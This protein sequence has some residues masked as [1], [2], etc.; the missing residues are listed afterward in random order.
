MA[1]LDC[2]VDVRVVSKR[3]FILSFR[4]TELQEVCGCQCLKIQIVKPLCFK[5]CMI[6]NYPLFLNPGLVVFL[7]I[8]MAIM[9]RF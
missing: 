3:F 8:K 1:V 4:I 7:I 9:S 5:V 2:K 6:L